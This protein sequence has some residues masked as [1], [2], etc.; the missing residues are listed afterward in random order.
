MK[1]IKNGN[2][3]TTTQGILK[4][5]TPLLGTKVYA[6]KQIV[7]TSSSM[8][9]SSKSHGTMR[10][11]QEQ[12]KRSVTDSVKKFIKTKNDQQYNNYSVIKSNTKINIPMNK[13]GKI[14]KFF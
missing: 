6:P 3:K 7:S 10:A 5:R 2:S 9:S 1:V 4:I 12:N 11:D 13:L 14:T 8:V